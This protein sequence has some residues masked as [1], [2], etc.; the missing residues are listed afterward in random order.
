MLGRDPR[1][2]GIKATKAIMSVAIVAS[3]PSKVGVW[4]KMNKLMSPNSQRGMKMVAS[5]TEGYL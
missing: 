1:I 2:V 3:L 5:A 4:K